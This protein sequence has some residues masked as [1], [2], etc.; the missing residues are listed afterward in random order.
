MLAILELNVGLGDVRV[1]HVQLPELGL[2]LV[3]TGD[4]LQLPFPLQ[5][6]VL[7]N[8][9]VITEQFFQLSKL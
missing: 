9:W 8:V 1:H 5:S 7:L 4:V 2:H 3:Q 6:L